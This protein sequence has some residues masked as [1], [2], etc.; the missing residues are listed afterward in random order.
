MYKRLSSHL[1]SLELPDFPD[2]PDALRE[3][4]NRVETAI[5][6]ARSNHETASRHSLNAASIAA[7]SVVNKP[8]IPSKPPGPANAKNSDN[9]RDGAA[10]AQNSDNSR[11]GAA[12]SKNS[13]DNSRDGAACSKNSD[14]NSR[15]GA[16][17]SKNSD[18]NSRDV[19][20]CSKNSDN[21][22]DGA[23]CTWTQL[24]SSGVQD[25]AENDHDQMKDKVDVVVLSCNENI[26]DET[27]DQSTPCHS[28]R[29]K[30]KEVEDSVVKASQV[31]EVI[32]PDDEY[33]CLM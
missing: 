14:D 10:C 11:D 29:N 24:K 1:P 25:I 8:S 27:Y 9:S 15:D 19:A 2:L 7:T 18:D 28:S 22:R 21:S 17:C 13:D 31:T 16:A 5:H 12:C 20:A 4:A 33:D 23:A 3:T 32:D 30:A 26:K 6:N